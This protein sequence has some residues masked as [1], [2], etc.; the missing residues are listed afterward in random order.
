M[1]TCRDCEAHSIDTRSLTYGAV[2]RGMTLTIKGCD[3]HR[4]ALVNLLD[5]IQAKND[6]PELIEKLVE[7]SD[8]DGGRAREDDLR[9][10]EKLVRYCLCGHEEAKH[11]EF[12]THFRSA[13]N[14]CEGNTPGGCICP[15][16]RYARTA[17]FRPA[18]R[19]TPDGLRIYKLE[20][21]Q[22]GNE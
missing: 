20:E 7:N 8:S 2:F 21:V 9:E 18:A 13:A 17:R 5:A 19:W 16:W 12:H 15:A 22:S 1:S 3:T 6:F 11:C 10:G 4:A 14:A